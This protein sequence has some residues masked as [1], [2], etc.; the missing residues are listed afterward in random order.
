MPGKG[1]KPGV[2]TGV[3]NSG[4]TTP[5]ALTQ[6]LDPLLL[7]LVLV[8]G[9]AP[10]ARVVAMPQARLAEAEPP[11]PYGLRK[12]AGFS[13]TPAKYS[14]RSQLIVLVVVLVI[15]IGRSPI[16]HEHEDDDENDTQSGFAEGLPPRHRAATAS[17]W[18]WRI[19]ASVLAQSFWMNIPG[20]QGSP[21]AC[22]MSAQSC[23]PFTA[24][25]II[26]RPVPRRRSNSQ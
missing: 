1:A 15:V 5:Q 3:L 4:G 8:L 17:P 24:L 14:A 20:R 10:V 9:F 19:S 2:G 11:K 26:T 7:V 21:T 18:S 6:A 23:A 12:A 25:A 13:L 16:Q 22:I